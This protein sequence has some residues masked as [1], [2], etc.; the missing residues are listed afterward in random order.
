MRSALGMRSV[1]G[2]R[3]ML[4][5]TLFVWLAVAPLPALRKPHVASPRSW[6]TVRWQSVRGFAEAPVP[7]AG[8]N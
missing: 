7:T 4:S 3:R 1:L 6:Q 2:M 8:R 5:T